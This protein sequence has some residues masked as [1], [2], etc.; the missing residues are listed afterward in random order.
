VSAYAFVTS[1][2]L[3]REVEP[4]RTQ[5]LRR[6]VPIVVSVYAK[7]AAPLE[8]LRIALTH[9]SAY[10]YGLSARLY[11]HLMLISRAMFSSRAARQ[12]AAPM[13]RSARKESRTETVL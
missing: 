10:R 5:A 9:L 11:Y 6:L 7:N 4:A 2:A 12:P 13:P 8:A 1:L 3:G